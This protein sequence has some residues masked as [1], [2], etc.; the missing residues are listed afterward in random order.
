MRYALDLAEKGRGRTSPNPMVGAVVVCGGRIVGEGYHRAPGKEHAEIAA[1][2]MAGDH[3]RG[4]T[5]YVNLEPCSH[6][7]RTGPCTE[8]IIDAGIKR[9]VLSLKDPNPLVNGRGIR[10]L[11]KYGITVESGLLREEAR[12]LND[13]YLGYHVNKRPYVIL[14]L[15]QS[16][17]GRI[18]TTTGA[19]KWISSV[20][21]RRFA[22]KLRAE[23][24]AV[25]VGA[26]TVRRDNPTLTVRHVRGRDPYRIILS[27]SLDIPAGSRLL[28]NN[29]D[30]KTVV[31]T[32]GISVNRL[33]GKGLKGS[34]ILWTVKNSARGRLD[35]HDFVSKA[36][37]FGLQS[38][39]VEGGASLATSFLRAGLVDKLVAITAPL[40]I[41]AGIN[42]L[43]DLGINEISEAVRFD[44]AYTVR[45]GPD[46]IF[47][48]Y[49]SK[50]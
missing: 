3:A 18:A 50:G 5:L 7:G 16:L 41:G 39:L 29:D 44:S 9:V 8:T 14:K 21:S 11:R 10:R 23:V 28:V 48:G 47:T 22:H 49:V 27:G 37:S 17:D 42:G 40:V 12:R 6:T 45:S 13:I 31:A 46:T 35:L 19:S 2:R 30:L 4:G 25:V 32:T 24:D 1:I 33:R 38:L 43:G 34:P 36:G 26:G 15:A 20:P